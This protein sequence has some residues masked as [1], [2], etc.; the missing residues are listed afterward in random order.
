MPPGWIA[1]VPDPEPADAGSR[2]Q[3]LE[4]RQLPFVQVRSEGGAR[5]EHARFHELRDIKAALHQEKTP[6]RLR[7]LYRRSIQKE[8]VEVVELLRF[9]EATVEVPRAGGRFLLFRERPPDMR[10]DGGYGLPVL[11]WPDAP[12]LED[13]SSRQRAAPAFGKTAAAQVAG[14]RRRD[15]AALEFRMRFI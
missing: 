7:L 13:E 3:L 8:T 10:Q 15:P 5:I 12:H 4:P 1:V 9:P 11:P 2:R 6:R 14:G